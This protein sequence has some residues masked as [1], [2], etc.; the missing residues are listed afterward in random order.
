M[1][2]FWYIFI[3]SAVYCNV[4]AV[5][6]VC[7]PIHYLDFAPEEPSTGAAFIFTRTAVR[8]FSSSVVRLRSLKAHSTY[9]GA[10]RPIAACGVKQLPHMLWGTRWRSWLMHCA[11]SR[12]FKVSIPAGFIGNFH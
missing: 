10:L 2:I 8:S 3:E 11:T 6:S 1:R 5:V 7:T 12:K 9:S 4:G